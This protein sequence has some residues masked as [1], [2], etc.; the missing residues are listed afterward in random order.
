MGY[1][2]GIEKGSDITVEPIRKIKYIK[3]ISKLLESNPRNYLLWIMGINNGLRASDLV[4]IKFSQVA[5]LK[6]GDAVKIIETKTGK[7]NFL[8]INK[9]VHKALQ[10]YINEVNPDPEDYLYSPPEKVT[11][12]YRATL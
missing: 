4:K 9:S 7:E 5:G 8:V 11:A 2:A 6:V 1:A 10:H 3:A 12:T